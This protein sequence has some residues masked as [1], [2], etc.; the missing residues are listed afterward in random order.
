MV[1][2]RDQFRF[3]LETRGEL[4][5]VD[6]LLRQDFQRDEPIEARFAREI[7]RRHAA[8][9]EARHD[10]VARK[11]RSCFKAHGG[12]PWRAPTK[13]KCS[14]ETGDFSEFS[15]A[16]CLR[17]SPSAVVSILRRRCRTKEVRL[18]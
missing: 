13:Q 6:Q 18:P 2:T 7:Y 12:F 10:G 15:G 14:K 1:Q 4:R 5:V 8:A 9:S 11:N 3:L 16:A 17:A